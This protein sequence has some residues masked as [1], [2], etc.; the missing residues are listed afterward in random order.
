MSVD[1]FKKLLN[2]NNIDAASN[3]INNNASMS[4]KCVNGNDN[5]CIIHATS[6]NDNDRDVAHMTKRCLKIIDGSKTTIINDDNLEQLK[7]MEIVVTGGK[8][9]KKSKKPKKKSK[10]PK[11]KSKKPKKP[12]KPKKSKKPVKPKKK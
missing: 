1:E 4:I 3:Y 11:K 9:K 5:K 6:D 7:T 10:K 2:N 12:I 8:P